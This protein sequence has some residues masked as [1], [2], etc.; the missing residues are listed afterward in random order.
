MPKHALASATALLVLTAPQAWAELTGPQIWS[1]WQEFYDR[2]GGSIVAADE[3]YEDGVLTLEGV[4]FASEMDGAAVESGGFGPIRMVERADGTVA[5]ELPANFEISTTT[6]VDGETV[7]QAAQFTNEGLDLVVS[8]DGAARIYDLAAETLGWSMEAPAE[9][10]PGRVAMVLTGVESAYTSGA[11]GPDSFAQSLSAAAAAVTAEAEGESPFNMSYAAEGI[12]S[13][14]SGTIGEPAEGEVASLADLNLQYGGEMTHS[15]STL[16]L[17]GTGDQGPFTVNGQSAGGGIAFDLGETQLSYGVTSRDAGATVTVAAFPVPVS[18]AMAELTTDLT[19]PVGSGPEARPLGME[20]SLVD[21][22]IDDTL[23]GLFDP[24]GQLP[25]DPATLRIDLS[26]EAV[27]SNDLFGGPEAMAGMAG[28]PGRMESLTISQVLLS[29]AGAEL[30]AA[31]ELAFPTPDPTAPVGS[32]DL[33]LDGGFGLL[34]SLVALGFVPAEQAGFIKG[35]A[36]AVSRPVGED[37]LESTIEFTEG[38]G[39]SA[40]GMPLR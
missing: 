33:A 13:A 25:R 4:R 29:L 31:G 30:R 35:M 10:A 32:I 21:L 24:T 17:E 12:A 36:G 9:E 3:T 39:I 5:I 8:E 6:T 27:M 15:G 38:G 1:D 2:F 26:G 23:W 28:P 22:V 40:N 20:V 18:V 14:F 7:T 11:E 16:V 19:L 37:Q 34:D